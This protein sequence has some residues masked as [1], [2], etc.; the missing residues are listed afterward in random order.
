MNPKDIHQ[1]GEAGQHARWEN[2][3]LPEGSAQIA[4]HEGLER[5]HFKRGDYPRKKLSNLPLGCEGP[6][7]QEELD[8]EHDGHL[9][10]CQ[11]E[12]GGAPGYKKIPNFLQEIS[13]QHQLH[14]MKEVKKHHS[15]E[16]IAL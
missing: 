5:E 14:S 11:A 13:V 8:E 6:S 3:D 9:P 10:S 16:L 2:I 1:A 12:G 7:H 15:R 4:G